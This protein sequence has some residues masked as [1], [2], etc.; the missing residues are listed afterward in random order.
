MAK[1]NKLT[2]NQQLFKKEQQRLKRA[3]SRA[4]KKGYIF[5]NDFIPEMPKRVT[6]KALKRIQD[7]KTP[8]IYYHAEKLDVNT[9]ELIKGKT[10][11]KLEKQQASKK[12]QETRRRNKEDYTQQRVPNYSR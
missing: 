12:A 7:F 3:V 8:Q 1:K 6:K 4:E 10:A 11:R 5:D 9:G 2:Q